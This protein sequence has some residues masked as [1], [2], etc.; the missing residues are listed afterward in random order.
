M[1]DIKFRAWDEKK[2]EWLD[3][4]AEFR[5][6][7]SFDGKVYSGLYDC[8]LDNVVIQQFT[9]LKDVKGTE[10]YEGD[11]VKLKKPSGKIVVDEVVFGDMTMGLN[12]GFGAKSGEYGY[13]GEDFVYLDK[14]EIIGNIFE[15]PELLEK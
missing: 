9:E 8:C 7:I 3:F 13:E 4:S 2:K 6:A 15:N 11:I 14:S 5:R 10:I 1:R 12:T